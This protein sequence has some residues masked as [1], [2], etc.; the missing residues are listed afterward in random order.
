METGRWMR[1]V[2]AV[3]T[4]PEILLPNL[5]AQGDSGFG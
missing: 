3:V 4:M 1:E 2:L 5:K